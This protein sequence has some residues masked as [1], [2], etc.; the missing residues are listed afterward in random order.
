MKDLEL[1]CT[2]DGEACGSHANQMCCGQH[3]R[4]ACTMCTPR[5]ACT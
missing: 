4:C 3:R 1:H 5:Y 2:W